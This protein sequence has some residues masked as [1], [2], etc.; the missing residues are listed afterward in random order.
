VSS[1]NLLFLGIKGTA[2]AVDRATGQEVWRTTLKGS[3]YVNVVL[4][5]GELYASSRGE[6]YRLDP[7][8]GAILW[9]N[10]LP[11]LGWGLISIGSVG[12]QQFGLLAEKKRHDDAAAAAATGTTVAG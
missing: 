11:G 2:L 5:G 12:S 1:N 9:R 4:D 10:E 7:S 3:E 8:S 6:I